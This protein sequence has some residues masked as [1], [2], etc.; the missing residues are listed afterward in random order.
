VRTIAIIPGVFL[1]AVA[2]LAADQ[3]SSGAASKLA[4]MLA[5]KDEQGKPIITPEERAY[6]DGL[7]DN[8]RALLNQAMQRERITRPEHLAVLLSLGLRPQKMEVLLQNN[9]VLC[10][11]DSGNQSAET[12]FTTASTATTP[13]SHMNLKEVVEDVHFRR[14]VSCA[15]CHGGDP[16]A[17]LGH[18]FVKEWPEKDRQKNRAW[19]VQFCARCHSDPAIM[20]E[21][22][23]SLPTDQLAKF[24][25]S[26]H[27]RTLME[28][29]D[30][31]APSCVSC[32]GVHG[33][34][35]AKDPQS[36]VYAQRVPETCGAC[37]ADPKIIA[38]FTRG[39]GSP[40]P[41]TQLTEYRT[42]VHGHALLVRG[43][44]GA[45]ACNT[46]HGNH[47]ASPPGVA[48]VSRSCSLCHSANASL[49]DGSNH[50]H[51]FDQHNWP[52]CGQCHNNHAIAKT[53]DSMLA[54][55]PGQ[56]CG[57]CHRQY[58]KDNPECV[59][60]A[61]YF[62]E[63]I[64]RMDQA[65]TGL[66]AVSEKLAA[67]GL[68]VEPISNE[69]TELGDALKKS[70]TY[71][72]SFSRNTFQQ[73]ALPGEQAVQRA[74]ALVTKAGEEYKYRQIGL[75]V[76]IAVIGLLMLAI[77]LKLRQLEK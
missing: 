10:H 71:V 23:P 29:H 62:H 1:I 39:D 17:D 67:K 21:F 74:D 65:R 45:P 64:T 8:L 77:Y 22:N 55:W 51:A 52:E 25:D 57:D 15:G 69:L 66:I 40:L 3:N 47:A 9:C 7:N 53:N 33:I 30:D 43:D 28:K 11:S 18:D 76:S 12:L 41:T 75:A 4:E 68:D 2:S 60:T 27:G 13:A 26:P 19:V 5:A 44:L 42:S 32:H 58:A 6:F 73:V 61:D 35:P 48:Q 14:G 56:L 37:H 16:T 72:H 50:K 38:G 34:R 63:T 46:C 36:K 49:F 59:K 20:H 54:T 70:R 24:K 31:R